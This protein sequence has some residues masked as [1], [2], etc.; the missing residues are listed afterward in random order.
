MI[1]R[2]FTLG[3]MGNDHLG[4]PCLG[5][6]VHQLV[7]RLVHFFYGTIPL[8]HQDGAYKQLIDGIPEVGELQR[9]DLIRILSRDIEILF[10]GF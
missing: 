10:G 8:V 4:D 3:Q 9:S 6:S 7:G 5:G 2:A 1:D